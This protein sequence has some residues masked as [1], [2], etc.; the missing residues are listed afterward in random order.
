MREVEAE[1]VL[2]VFDGFQSGQFDIGVAG[3]TARVDAP[4][5][6]LGL[7]VNDLL[8]QQPAVA[9]AF[10][11]ACAQADDAEGIALA[12]DRANKRLRH[13]WYR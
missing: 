11:N 6:I 9:P 5:V 13:R 2:V 4:R 7:A 1:F 3:K 12:G 10:A 8:G